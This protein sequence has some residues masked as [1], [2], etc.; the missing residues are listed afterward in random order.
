MIR[1]LLEFDHIQEPIHWLESQLKGSVGLGAMAHKSNPYKKV[2]PAVPFKIVLSSMECL[3]APDES[4]RWKRES[5]RELQTEL[6]RESDIIG[7]LLV[8][9]TMTTHFHPSCATSWAELQDVSCSTISIA[10][11]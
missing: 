1:D 7:S 6:K 9:C 2:G 10:L 3:F 11:D 4:S 8:L 5:K